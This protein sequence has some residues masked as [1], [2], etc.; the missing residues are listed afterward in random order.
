MV[1]R[2]RQSVITCKRAV[3]IPDI[4]DAPIDIAEGCA[5]FSS[6]GNPADGC[7]GPVFQS[8]V[9]AACAIGALRHRLGMGGFR[10]H[11]AGGQERNKRT[12][13][14]L[15]ADTDVPTPRTTK[16][17]GARKAEAQSPQPKSNFHQN[18]RSGQAAWLHRT[19]VDASEAAALDSETTQCCLNYGSAKLFCSLTTQPA[20]REG[21]QINPSRIITCDRRPLRSPVSV[22]E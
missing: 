21:L 19:T 22:L 20:G 7:E 3:V 1:R 15:Q 11:G 13:K 2:H 18:L 12:R 14:D 8:Y 9:G 10:E 4:A 16:I 5:L 17:V 6:V